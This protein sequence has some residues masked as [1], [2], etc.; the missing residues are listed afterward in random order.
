MVK[1]L[2]EALKI[3]LFLP[4]STSCRSLWQFTSQ[5]ILTLNAITTTRI[6]KIPNAEG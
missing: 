1:T 4:I 5:M 6:R 3:S 2:N